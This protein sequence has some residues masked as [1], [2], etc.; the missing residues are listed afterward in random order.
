[1]N[2]WLI[3]I[4]VALGVMGS[5]VAIGSGVSATSL[6]AQGIID[7]INTRDEGEA[8]KRT[9]TIQMINAK[10]KVRTRT[11]QVYRGNESERTRTLISFIKPRS[12]KNMSFL[13][14]DQID[15]EKQDSQWLYLPA[16]KKSRRIPSSNIHD[17]FLGT[18]F[19]YKDVKVEFKVDPIAY[20]FKLKSLDEENQTAVVV[21]STLSDVEAERMGHYAFQIQVDMKSWIPTEVIYFEKNGSKQKTMTLN[22][23]HKIEDIWT[24]RIIESLD[25]SNNNKT[26][27]TYTDIQYLDGFDETVFDVKRLGRA[28]K[29]R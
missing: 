11:A 24:P 10:G 26:V 3:L 12:V 7:K 27:F 2:K 8:I 23:I 19:S 22:D 29:I 25:H 17:S 9:L 5:T 6:D 18:T 13:T 16:L 1:M 14:Y 20:K 15:P 28:N 21:G 4:L